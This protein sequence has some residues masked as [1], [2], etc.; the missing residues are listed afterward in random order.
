MAVT[1]A[2]ALAVTSTTVA[3]T[4]PSVRHSLGIGPAAP[5]PAYAVG[6][7]IDV[8]AEIFDGAP[9]TL[10]LFFRS[11]CGACE[12]I[13]SFLSKLAARNN[14]TTVRVVAVTGPQSRESSVAFA[15]Q[16]GLD[17]AHLATVDVTK[18]RLKTVPAWVLVDRSGQIHAAFEGIPSPGEQD[19]LLRT[20]TALAQTR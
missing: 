1:L 3:L 14:G 11:G 9:N 18:L 12:R 19:Q 5:A 2:C 20:V 15:R 7:T 17:E 13:K 6:D 8:P 16:I 4:M 10:L